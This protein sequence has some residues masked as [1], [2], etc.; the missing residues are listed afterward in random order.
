MFKRKER[1]FL[2]A[3]LTYDMAYTQKQLDL[4]RQRVSDMSAKQLQTRMD[5]MSVQ[6]KLEAFA[7]ALRERLY[8]LSIQGNNFLFKKYIS[9]FRICIHKCGFSPTFGFF[10]NESIRDSSW[11]VLDVHYLMDERYLRTARP[12]ELTTAD[13][14]Y[15][16]FMYGHDSILRGSELGGRDAYIAEQVDENYIALLR[17]TGSLETNPPVEASPTVSSLVTFQVP[18]AR[19]KRKRP[20]RNLNL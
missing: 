11:G 5:R 13:K 2:A 19:S 1:K 3:T 15:L 17:G 9:L 16:R 8:G 6:G 7:I 12:A 18:L 14:T 10:T 4:A 20:R